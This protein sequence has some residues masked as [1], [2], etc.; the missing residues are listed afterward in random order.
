M[1]PTVTEQ[2]HVATHPSTKQLQVQPGIEHEF[3]QLDAYVQPEH[4]PAL[5]DEDAFSQEEISNRAKVKVPNKTIFLLNPLSIIFPS[6]CM[7][8]RI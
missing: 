8:I 7:L 4:G 5:H 1:P 3:E 2:V 6:F